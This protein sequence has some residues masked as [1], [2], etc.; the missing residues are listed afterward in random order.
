LS[1]WGLGKALNHKGRKAFATDAKKGVDDSRQIGH[2]ELRAG[3][4]RHPVGHS[5]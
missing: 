1:L 3:M 4:A 5:A 2:N